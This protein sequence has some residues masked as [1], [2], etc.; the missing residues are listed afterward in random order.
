[1]INSHHVKFGS[2]MG[3]I[4]ALMLAVT[5]AVSQTPVLA[6]ITPAPE[7]F[8]SDESSTDSS[9]STGSGNEDDDGSTDSSSSDDNDTGTYDSDEDSSSSDDGETIEESTDTSDSDNDGSGSDT[10]E[11]DFDDSSSLMESIMNRVNEK[12]SAAGIATPG[13]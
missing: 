1:M 4:C 10:I 11:Q 3:L 12:L 5:A 8:G 9:P 6:Q 7:K 2:L 13:F